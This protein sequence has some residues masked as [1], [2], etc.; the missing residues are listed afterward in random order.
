MSTKMQVDNKVELTFH[1]F[2]F[3]AI[4]VFDFQSQTRFIDIL[5]DCQGLPYL[6]DI[7]SLLSNLT[8]FIKYRKYLRS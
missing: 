8:L 4:F 1:V 6:P 5:A 7:F 2:D 3:I